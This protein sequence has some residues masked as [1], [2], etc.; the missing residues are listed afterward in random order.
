ML[1][2]KEIALC[3]V[4]IGW[5]RNCDAVKV[6]QYSGCEWYGTT[7]FCHSYCPQGTTELLSSDYGDG[8]KCVTGKNTY[9]ANA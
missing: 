1:F 3:L 4:F 8:R 6:Y 9:V 2:I 7:P 5:I